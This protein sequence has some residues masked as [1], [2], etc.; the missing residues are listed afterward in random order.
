MAVIADHLDKCTVSLGQRQSG[1]QAELSDRCLPSNSPQAQ[2]SPAST[3]PHAL[4]TTDA[5]L[6]ASQADQGPEDTA[7]AIELEA[8]LGAMCI[9]RS[10]PEV[11]YV[12]LDTLLVSLETLP[13]RISK[14]RRATCLAHRR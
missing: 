3:P 7:S 1:Q 12:A 13:N 8:A 9:T 14:L 6:Q 4:T 2:E 5:E 10:G 11:E